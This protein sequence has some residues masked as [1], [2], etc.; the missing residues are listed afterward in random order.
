MV[1]VMVSVRMVMVVVTLLVSAA[2][3]IVFI[4]PICGFCP[5]A[6]KYTKKVSFSQRLRGVAR[7][8]LRNNEVGK[9]AGNS[10]S[11]SSMFSDAAPLSFG[12]Y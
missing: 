1:I 3:M 7:F 4:L 2:M 11:V 10:A 5:R 6:L 12:Q 8:A 9:G